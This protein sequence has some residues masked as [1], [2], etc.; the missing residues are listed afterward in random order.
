MN[1]DD[2]FEVDLYYPEIEID[3]DDEP[4]EEILIHENV[5]LHLEDLRHLEWEI[6]MLNVDNIAIH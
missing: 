6:N 3:E 4:T 1:N 2:N 5:V